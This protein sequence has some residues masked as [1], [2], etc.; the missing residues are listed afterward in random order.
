MEWIPLQKDTTKG[1]FPNY[2]TV[3]TRS[4]DLCLPAV[5]KNTGK[6][7]N[8][9][10]RA[11][12]VAATFSYK[13]LDQQPGDL[14]PMVVCR[15]SKKGGSTH[16]SP[17]RLS[18]RKADVTP[19]C[20]SNALNWRIKKWVLGLALVPLGW[21]REVMLFYRMDYWPSRKKQ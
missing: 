10:N 18:K 3:P 14:L 17:N 15:E 8:V 1:E 13:L 20:P 5:H 11:T 19:H 6:K 7:H 12:S 16:L 4:K 9:N 21:H 2:R